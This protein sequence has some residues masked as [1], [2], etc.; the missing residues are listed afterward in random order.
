[1]LTNFPGQLI[2]QSLLLLSLA[3][4]A[5]LHAATDKPNIVFVMTDDMGW[6]DTAAYGSDFHQTP[7]IDR[8]ASQG[9]RFT[10]A[11]VNAPLCSPAR[12]CLFSGWYT[13]R[14]GVYTVWTSETGSTQH[15][16]LIPVPTHALPNG[17]Y[18]DPANPTIAS[19]LAAAGYRTMGIGK[20]HGHDA[21]SFQEFDTTYNPNEEQDPKSA[22]SYTRKA[23]EYLVDSVTN[24]PDQPFFLQIQT[25]GR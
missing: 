14:H 21:S 6:N 9:M 20:C 11:Y 2:V 17:N 8:L 4:S 13:P 12:A 5:M 24:H 23:K 3:A 1:M 18:I 16:K 10:D 7:N 25:D 15:R 19:S 22:Y